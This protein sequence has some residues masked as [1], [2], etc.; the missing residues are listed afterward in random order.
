M[1]ICSVY[2]PYPEAMKLTSSETLA[3]WSTSHCVIAHPRTQQ[4]LVSNIFVLRN[5][6]HTDTKEKI[7]LGQYLIPK[8]PAFR[9]LVHLTI[10]CR[11]LIHVTLEEQWLFKN[12]D[13]YCFSFRLSVRM[14][15]TSNTRWSATYVIETLFCVPK[16]LL[17]WTKRLVTL[18]S[19]LTSN[20]SCRIVITMIIQSLTK[21]TLVQIFSR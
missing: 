4:I 7:K 13:K 19:C 8:I 16:I 18:L 1:I 6:Y 17:Y 12:N 10:V 11:L 9:R 5:E 14:T 20:E 21:C 2:P 3:H 15:S